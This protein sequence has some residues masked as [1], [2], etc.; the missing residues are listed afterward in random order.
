MELVIT[1]VLLGFIFSALPSL[2]LQN[3]KAATE[4][5]SQEAIYA[6]VAKMSQVLS[7]H[8]DENSIEDNASLATIYAKV[9]DTPNGSI[10]LQRKPQSRYRIGHFEGYSRRSFFPEE[11]NASTALGPDAPESA[12]D[13]DDFS[14]NN[15]TL[16][17]FDSEHGYKRS[18]TMNTTVSYID[19]RAD[20]NQ[21][22]INGFSFSNTAPVGI[23]TNIK[24][25][26]IEVR[27]NGERQFQFDS[28]ISNIGETDIVSRVF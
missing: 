11:V 8:F 13:I 20:Y 9:L 4:T 27:L 28:F 2:L 1:I 6:A 22:V 21:T 17:T 15:Q 18:Y 19:D 12:D 24:M 14:G 7:Y 5:L 16:I 3:Q 23:P 25:L 10:L 26:S